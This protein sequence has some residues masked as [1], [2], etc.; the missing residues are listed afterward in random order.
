MIFMK[1]LHSYLSARGEKKSVIPPN[2]KACDS[3]E[4]VA[5]KDVYKGTMVTRSPWE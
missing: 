1:S 2:C 3:Q 5:Y 4:W